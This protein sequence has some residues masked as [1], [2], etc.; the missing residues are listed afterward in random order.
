MI[1]LSLPSILALLLAAFFLVGAAVNAIGPSQIR[2]D[3]ARWGY[4]DG[5]RF[6][7]AVL[8]LTTAALLFLPA[9]RTIGVMLGAVVMTGALLTLLRNKEVRHAIAP[10]V[11]II[12]LLAL[13]ALSYD[14]LHNANSDAPLRTQ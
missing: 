2:A 8:E 9:Y 10:T 13:Y 5:F 6:F 7:T 3:Y 14:C 12:L 1:D 11:V 4:P